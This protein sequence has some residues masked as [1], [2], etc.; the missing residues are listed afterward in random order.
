MQLSEIGEFGLIKKLR[1]R[2]APQFR[3]V[4]TGIGDD[5]AVVSIGSKKTL[6]TSDMMNEGIHFDLSYTTFYQ[7]G[8]KFL[9]VNVSDI[10][11]MGG[12][13]EYFIVNLGLPGT[14]LSENIDELYS[15]ILKCA[16]KHGVTVVGGDTCA[17]KS[18][19]VLSG[20]LT[21]QGRKII[22]RSGARVGDGI[23]VNRSLGDSAM[24]LLLLRKRK[25]SVE[26]FLPA[27]SGMNLMKRHLMPDPAPLKNTAGVTAMIDVSDGLLRDVSH[28]CDESRV[29]VVV[30]KD[31]IPLSSEMVRMAKKM[32][33]DP[34]DLALKGGE[35]YSLLFTAPMGFKT[36]AFRIGEITRRGRYL[37]DQNGEK[38]VM[39]PEGY[40]HFKKKNSK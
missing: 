15:G 25:K 29:G 18:G 23:F 16:K 39:K 7:L 21:G 36:R 5:A 24:G 20:T 13:P 34:F 37:I 19:L 28:I 8:Y 1:R 22:T 11:A 38:T 27:N 30:Y 10:F 17:S 6:I 2:C 3:D 40:E 31:K 35:D 14:M 12:E 33:V 9:A 4:L 26:R 32:K